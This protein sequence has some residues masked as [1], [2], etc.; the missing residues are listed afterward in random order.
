[1]VKF[2]AI[3][4]PDFLPWLGFFHKM[5][6]SDKFIIFDTVP[7]S[8]G[9]SWSSRVQI[10][11]NGKI[12]WLSIPIKRA[13]KAG[14]R[15]CEVEIDNPRSNW[16]R[17]FKTLYLAYHKC[18][19]FPEVFDFLKEAVNPTSLNLAEVCF[20]IISKT[21]IK[22]NLKPQILCTSENERLLHSTQIKTELIVEVCKEYGIRHYLSGRGCLDFLKPELFRNAGIEIVF[23]SFS[24]PQYSQLSS[25]QF[26]KGLSAFDALF[27]IGFEKT[28]NLICSI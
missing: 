24:E 20:S 9:K 27:N 3:H 16:E 7:I 8:T 15:I 6:K 12:Y 4:Q 18:P 19:H 1:M 28:R 17:I 25:R 2:S 22:L 13:G 11:L 21:A 14:Q 23:Q 5:S 26:V 10:L